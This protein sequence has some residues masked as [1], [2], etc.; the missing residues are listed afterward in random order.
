MRCGQKVFLS[1]RVKTAWL[2]Q[3]ESQSENSLLP[4]PQRVFRHALVS[5]SVPIAFRTELTII[6]VE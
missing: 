2:D 5:T 6:E 4:H 3:A 1:V